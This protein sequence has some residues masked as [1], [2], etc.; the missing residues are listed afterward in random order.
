MVIDWPA[1]ATSIR[2]DNNILFVLV[3]SPAIDTYLF[4]RLYVN[5][6]LGSTIV[7][8][9][10]SSYIIFLGTLLFLV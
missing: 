9:V 3:T 2:C 6:N 1:R 5:G 4:S 7:I 10:L 8:V